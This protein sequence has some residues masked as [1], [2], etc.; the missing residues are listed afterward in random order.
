MFEARLEAEPARINVS[1]EVEI[2]CYRVVQ[3]ALNNIARHAK[4][5]NVRVEVALREGELRLL[6]RDDGVGFDVKAARERA[7][8]GA[9]M[10][11]LTMSERHLANAG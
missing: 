10:G 1:P 9:S 11:L 5:H 7:S 3:E 6:I 4:A 2:G 8:H